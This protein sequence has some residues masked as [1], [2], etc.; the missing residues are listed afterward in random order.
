MLEIWGRPYSSN[1]IPVIWT[2]EELG[3][4][5]RLELAGGSFG[6]L[7]TDDYGRINP[8][9]MIP[10][11]R[12][13]DFAL[14]ESHAII[15]YLSG[16]YGMGALCPEDA[17]TRAVADRRMEWCG[18]RAFPPVIRAFLATVRTEPCKRDPG[19]IDGHSREAADVF[20]ILDRHLADRPYVAGGTFTSVSLDPPVVQ[21][22]IGKAG[23]SYPAFAASDG[24]AVNIL[25]ARQQDPATR[26][27][28][29][30]GNR[31]ETVKWTRNHGGSPL[32]TETSGWL[33]CR[34]RDRIDT[35]SHEILLGEVLHFGR[36]ENT[37]PHSSGGLLPRPVCQSSTLEG[38][39]ECLMS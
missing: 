37:L 16:R 8:N 19:L 6:R 7:D 30:T 9:R 38:D 15:R 3:L 34:V 32:L 10:A 25:T 33:D 26:F 11:I 22:C 1:V 31:F 28:G 12:D 29:R 24:F 36:N 4:A 23:L 21:V 5:F 39:A 20:P 14:W 18:T 27:A 13:G 35:G 2:A 17:E